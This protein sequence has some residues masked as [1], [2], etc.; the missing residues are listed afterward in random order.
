[1]KIKIA[2]IGDCCIDVYPKEKKKFPGG[3]AYNVAFNAQ[4]AGAN[5]SIVSAIGDDLSAQI[6]HQALKKNNINTKYL[7]V[8][9]GAT[10]SVEITI[11]KKGKPSY[12]NWDLGVLKKFKLNNFHQKFFS[13]QHIV[14]A[15]LFRP[16]EHIFNRFYQMRLPNTFKVG[17]FAGASEYSHGTS[18]I[19]NYVN[20]LDLIVKSI[21]KSDNKSLGY[22]K[23]LAKNY[24]K[25]ILV[26]MGNKGSIIFDKDKFYFQKSINIKVKDTTGAG[27]AYI[28]YFLVNYYQKKDIKE[29]MFRAASEASKS[30]F[31]LGAI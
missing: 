4:K 20:N 19:N 31:H 16:I 29:S 22:F 18:I 25:M 13:N 14:H 11:N 9:H 26:L 7:S 1:M 2:S 6:F 21:D 28:A 24:K 15:V 27:D 17:D 30:V 10:S 5:V 23:N 8:I 3:T 12:S